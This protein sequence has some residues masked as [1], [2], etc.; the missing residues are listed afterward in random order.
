MNIIIH[1][2]PASGKTTTILSCLSEK[3]FTFTPELFKFFSPETV[4][5]EFETVFEKDQLREDYIQTI[6][7][8]RLVISERDHLST[9]AYH[10]A[11]GRTELKSKFLKLQH[12][13]VTPD[14]YVYF[15]IPSKLSSERR[16][17]REYHVFDDGSVKFLSL[18]QK[19]CMEFIRQSGVKY[20]LL[21]ATVSESECRNQLLEIIKRCE[22]NGKQK[23]PV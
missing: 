23:K 15:I 9:F 10:V 5:R 12:T 4:G 2:L 11:K 14:A 1:G 21:D 3:Q 18:F 8:G 7:K 19:Y 16:T 6:S 20:Y 13:L 17:K 22:K